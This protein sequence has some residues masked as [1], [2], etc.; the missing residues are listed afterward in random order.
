MF[1]PVSGAD[2]GGEADARTIFQGKR[3]KLEKK[4]EFSDF[5][6]NRKNRKFSGGNFELWVV[7]LPPRAR[8][9]FAMEALGPLTS[10][11]LVSLPRGFWILFF[12][13]NWS[14]RSSLPLFKFT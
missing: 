1:C 12:N 10:L 5:F 7:R 9:W 8:T 13:G 14:S 4:D 6:H 11:S 2:K 3:V